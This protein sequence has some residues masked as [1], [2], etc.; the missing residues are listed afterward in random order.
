[1]STQ[2]FEDA[3]RASEKFIRQSQ[4]GILILCNQTTVMWLSKK[5]NSVKTLNF[6]SKFTALKIAVELVIAFRYKLHMFG[7]PLEGPTEMFYDN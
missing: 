3:Y 5:H 4:T 6:R 7:V 2:C 1:M